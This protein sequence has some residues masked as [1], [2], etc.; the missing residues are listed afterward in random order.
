MDASSPAAS[1]WWTFWTHYVADTFEPWWKAFH[2][3]VTA[4][5]ELAIQPYQPSLQEDVEA[6]TLHDPHNAAFSLPDGTK[7]DASA[8]MKEAFHESVGELSRTLGN[9]PTQW[10]WGKLHTREI[11]SQLG[12]EPLS[13]G[14]RASGG[15]DWTPNAAAVNVLKSLTDPT[16]RPSEHGPG[17]RMIV[18]WGSGQAETV[19]PGG[20]DENPASPWYEN[21]IAAWWTGHYYPMI[22]GSVAQRQPG[23]V[24]WRLSN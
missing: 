21:E 22:D 19:Y 14:P 17:W 4:H 10:Q 13:Y 12:P 9:D 23:S 7:R 18:D 3:S 6:W 20:L 1:L 16:L 5:P 24:T 15:D 11:Y 8:V 2:V